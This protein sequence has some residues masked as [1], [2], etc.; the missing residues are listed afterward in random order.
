MR[1]GA[2]AGQLQGK[3]LQGQGRPILCDFTTTTSTSPTS[4]KLLYALK[5]ANLNGLCSTPSAWRTC[6]SRCSSTTCCV[7]GITFAIAKLFG[8]ADHTETLCAFQTASFLKCND[9]R[10]L[11]F[12]I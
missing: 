8:L 2:G 3:G 6:D 4:Y 5:Y 1:Q 9:K 12:Y 11:V 7:M 10:V